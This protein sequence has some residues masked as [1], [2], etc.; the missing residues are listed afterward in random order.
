MQKWPSSGQNS[1][2]TRYAAT[3]HIIDAGNVDRLK[4]KWTFTAAG[5][6]SATATV[7]NEVA[8]VPDWG[9]KLWTSSH[10]D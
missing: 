7:V 1:H 2:S 6:V 4:P 9:A 5:D 10:V 8:Y 3:E